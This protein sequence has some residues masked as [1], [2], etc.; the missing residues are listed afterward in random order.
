MTMY[1]YSGPLNINKTQ[2]NVNFKEEKIIYL[3]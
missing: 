1:M 3:Y 2:K